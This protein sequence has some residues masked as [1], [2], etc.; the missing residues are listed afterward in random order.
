MCNFGLNTFIKYWLFFQKDKQNSNSPIFLK[1]SRLG[2]TETVFASNVYLKV[3]Q[4]RGK[5]HLLC[6]LLVWI[7]WAG[8]PLMMLGFVQ[9]NLMWCIMSL[10]KRHLA[11]EIVAAGLSSVER[12]QR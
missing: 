12:Q 5:I 9:V 7:F 3:Q 11:S 8:C 1:W 10:Q 2:L 4:T 6:F